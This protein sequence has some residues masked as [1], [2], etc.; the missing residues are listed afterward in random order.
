MENITVDMNQVK[1]SLQ[2]KGLYAMKVLQEQA[3]LVN[4][5]VK[6]RNYLLQSAPN[7]N[8]VPFLIIPYSDKF[9]S[10]VSFMVKCNQDYNCEG[11]Y[12]RNECIKKVIN[13]IIDRT[14]RVNRHNTL[15]IVD[16]I[17]DDSN[18]RLS[19]YHKEALN[20]LRGI[21]FRLGE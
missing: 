11:C 3:A 5:L 16:L 13:K 15:E 12:Y 8:A 4:G 7:A 1:M 14:K 17:N 10:L 9:K 18:V 20:L 2:R 19:I 21:V 6:L